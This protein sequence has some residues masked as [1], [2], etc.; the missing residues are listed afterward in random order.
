MRVWG[1]LFGLRLW[2][3]NG[4]AGYQDLSVWVKW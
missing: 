3:A 2:I 4:A 1:R